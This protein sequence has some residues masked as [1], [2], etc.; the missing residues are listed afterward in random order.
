MR[1]IV[2]AALSS[3]DGRSRALLT[4]VLVRATPVLA[5]VPRRA[6]GLAS[7]VV[8]TTHVSVAFVEVQGPR[9]CRPSVGRPR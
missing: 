8:A 4:R 5:M 1:A 3:S 9:T 7:L 6:D 2:H